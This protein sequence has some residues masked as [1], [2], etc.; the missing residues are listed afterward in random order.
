MRG[1]SIHVKALFFY[2]FL[3]VP[4]LDTIEKELACVA[5]NTIQYY[6]KTKLP[7]MIMHTFNISHSPKERRYSTD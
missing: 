6:T 4:P 1:F 2:L 3:H 7:Q 5:D